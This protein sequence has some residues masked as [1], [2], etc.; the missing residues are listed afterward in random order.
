MVEEPLM[1]RSE[2]LEVALRFDQGG[3]RVCSDRPVRPP[4]L[5]G[6]VLP[7]A[8]G[9]DLM[10]AGRPVHRQTATAHA[11]VIQVHDR[12]C[13]APQPVRPAVIPSTDPR[14]RD[15]A[16]SRVRATSVP[17]PASASPRFIPRAVKGR[18]R[19]ERPVDCTRQGVAV[20]P[21]RKGPLNGDSH[22]PRR[23]HR[24]A[25]PGT[26]RRPTRRAPLGPD[27]G[28]SPCR[29]SGGQPPHR[30][31]RH[32]P[33]PRTPPRRRITDPD[34]QVRAPGPGP[35]P[36]PQAQARPHRLP[37]T[38]HAGAP[39]RR[40]V[41]LPGSAPRPHP[42]PHRH[43]DD[44]RRRDPHPRAPRDHR[45]RPAPGRRPP[46]PHRRHQCDG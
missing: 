44:L 19:L 14:H 21:A 17:S 27:V 10:R 13:D 29:H 46:R 28:S 11:R 1:T 35:G 2:C 20:T 32:P 3:S 39:R 23:P 22:T 33:D 41:P 37:Q 40:E 30:R 16:E 9:T 18:Q 43:G 7:E 31:L 12:Y 25:V 34:A 15:S 8:H 6:V 45:H 24:P 36:E 4:K 38:H 5:H 42:P 26:A